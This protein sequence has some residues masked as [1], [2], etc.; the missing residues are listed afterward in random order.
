[1]KIEIDTVPDNANGAQLSGTVKWFNNVK[2]YG[3]IKHSSGKDVFVHYS[4]ISDQGFKT[5]NEGDEVVYELDERVKGLYAKKVERTKAGLGNLEIEK[6][7]D[8]ENIMP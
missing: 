3:F 8:T 7:I 6:E 1:M 2:G 4:V 5:L